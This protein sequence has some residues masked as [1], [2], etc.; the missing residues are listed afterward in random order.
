MRR[1]LTLRTLLAWV[2]GVLPPDEQEEFGDAVAGSRLARLLAEQ[3]REAAQ[4]GSTDIPLISGLTIADDLN[5]VAEYLDN[6]L[7]SEHLE[8]FERLC[9]ESRSHL[10]EV[11]TCHWVLAEMSRN[12]DLATQPR[13]QRRGLRRRVRDALGETSP[14]P[15]TPPSPPPVAPPSPPVAPPAEQ[16]SRDS[17]TVEKPAA[18]SSGHAD[19]RAAA[20]ASVQAMLSRPARPVLPAPRDDV[21][22]APVASLD[23]MLPALQQPA[24]AVSREPAASS[25]AAA[26]PPS[27][28]VVT[29]APGYFPPVASPPAASWD[30]RGKRLPAWTGWATAALALTV[31][32]AAGG[33][34]MSPLRGPKTYKPEPGCMH[35]TRP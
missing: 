30:G 21:R 18:A 3:I 27:T 5:C 22:Q 12:V 6:T 16:P 9:I 10:A 7:P 2:D 17:I 35:C 1:R 33:A 19:A 26:S 14:P 32:L 34:L 13:E 15:V 20:E 25:S 11:A 28:P 24:D 4:W 8:A 29:P 23:G 31:L